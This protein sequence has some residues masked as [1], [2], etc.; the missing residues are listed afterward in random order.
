MRR[1]GPGAPSGELRYGLLSVRRQQLVHRAVLFMCEDSFQIREHALV[2]EADPPPPVDQ[3][4]LGRLQVDPAVRQE[5]E[6]VA[7][8]A[9]CT[10]VGGIVRIKEDEL[11][12]P[13]H[14]G[15]FSKEGDPI[16]GPVVRPLERFDC[17]VHE[18]RIE[19]R[20]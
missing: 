3:I 8:S 15:V 5:D 9:R 14:G 17:R 16:Q 1:R 10:H 12:C 18:G 19:V 13:C 6:V 11:H 4:V 7:M 2:L 20:G